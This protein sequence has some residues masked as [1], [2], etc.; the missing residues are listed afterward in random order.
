MFNQKIVEQV[1]ILF[2]IMGIG[3]F[4]RKKGILNDYVK[5]GMSELILTITLP[6][7]ILSSFN[8]KFSADLMRNAAFIFIISIGIHVFSFLISKV[9]FNKF[10]DDKK[11]VLRYVTVISNAG[12]MGF[13]VLDVLYGKAGIFYASI[14]TIPFNIF[15]LTLG[16]IL[17]S[18][19]KEEGLF[20]RIAL[21]PTIL[22]VAIGFIPFYFSYELPAFFTRTVSMVGGMTTPLS[23]LVIGAMIADANIKGI[24]EGSVL[25]GSAIRLVGIP[26]VTYGILKL[27]G[28]PGE[29]IGVSVVL[30]A[31][32][33]GAMTAILATKYNSNA[34]FASQCVFV[35]TLFSIITIPL[36]LMLL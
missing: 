7:L 25:Y 8:Q 31:M 35:S 17:F 6:L 16:V 28:M 12:F 1:A 36:I 9:L 33:A 22:A 34:V 19:K 4:A 3:V 32:P 14:Y 13:P 24:F 2:I 23:M 5:K 18:G 27:L 20:K 11:S 10:P 29:V 15:M 30:T 21:H 26:L